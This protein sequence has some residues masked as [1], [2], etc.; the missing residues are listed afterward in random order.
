[1]LVAHFEVHFTCMSSKPNS[2]NAGPQN[3]KWQKESLLREHPMTSVLDISHL[4]S[5]KLD[6]EDSFSIPWYHFSDRIEDF[7]GEASMLQAQVCDIWWVLLYG[8]RDGFPTLFHFCLGCLM[9]DACDTWQVF[10]SKLPWVVG[11]G[12]WLLIF[13]LISG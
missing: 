2:P 8:F 4:E 7:P 3:V 1:M 11:T 12:C 5:G 6:L 9:C 10:F 13:A